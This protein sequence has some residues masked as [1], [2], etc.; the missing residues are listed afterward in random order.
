VY[1]GPAFAFPDDLAS[2]AGVVVVTDI[3]VLERNFHG[4]TPEEI[5]ERSPIIATVE[6]GDAVSI[7]FCARRTGA[8]AEA[9]VETAA[10]FRGRGLA[11]V[12]TTTWAQALRSSGRTPIYSTEWTNQ[13]S[14]AV[15]RKLR[16]VACL[17]DWSVT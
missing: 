6:R 17:C 7:C 10:P 2:V 14:L 9:G 4:W 13:A 5:P 16:M 1:A 12:V 11:P 3:A 15:A 8:A